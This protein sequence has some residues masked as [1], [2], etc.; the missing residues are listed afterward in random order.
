M[1]NTSYGYGLQPLYHKGGEAP[2]T[3]SFPLKASYGTNI[4]KGQ[5][6]TWNI[7]NGYLQA[8]ASTNPT[9]VVGV[10]ATCFWTGKATQTTL[11]VW[12][13][14]DHV[15]QIQSDSA[16]TT[17]TLAQVQMKNMAV[18]TPT[19]G[20]TLTHYSTMKL[21]WSSKT[22]ST[23]VLKVVGQVDSIEKRSTMDYVDLKV[24]FNFGV[25]YTELAHE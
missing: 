8:N 3:S 1:A 10:A 5:I 23:K 6:V 18:T 19:A 7:T 25:L 24:E 20:S 12:D 16:T 22:T 11:Q 14:R 21:K 13:G 17:N 2:R 15:F 9:K 4:Y